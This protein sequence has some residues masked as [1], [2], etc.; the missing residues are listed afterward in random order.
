VLVE[1]VEGRVG[2]RHVH[3]PAGAEREEDTLLDPRYREPHAILASLGGS[4]IT[5]LERGEET[6][7]HSLR[8]GG[9]R[10]ARRGRGEQRQALLQIALLGVMHHGA[11]T[12]ERRV[13]SNAV[14]SDAVYGSFRGANRRC[15]DGE[16]DPVE[17]MRWTQG[18]GVGMAACA[19]R[20]RSQ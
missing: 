11:P 5:A 12:W 8:V 20:A 4:E 14:D 15:D 9:K 10:L 18:V 7:H 6:L 17:D 16:E 1:E 3:Q 13:G 19:A 2:R